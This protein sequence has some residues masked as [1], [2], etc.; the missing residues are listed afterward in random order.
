MLLY[1]KFN[2]FL[3]GIVSQSSLF[4]YF[5]P[6]LQHLLLVIIWKRNHI[7]KKTSLIHF[8]CLSTLQITS[9][10]IYQ[11]IKVLIEKIALV[12]EFGRVALLSMMELGDVWFEL[13]RLISSM[14]NWKNINKIW[15]LSSL[16][17][18][19]SWTVC[20]YFALW[21]VCADLSI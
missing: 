9:T 4:L 1:S 14:K 18:W 17:I 11:D 12:V 2:Q 19:D 21:I 7:K 3:L 10:Q 15:L 20:V 8:Q 5:Q 16:L 6:Y 13:F